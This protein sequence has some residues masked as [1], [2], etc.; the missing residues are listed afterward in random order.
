MLFTLEMETEEQYREFTFPFN[1]VKWNL[2]LLSVSYQCGVVRSQPCFHQLHVLSTTLS[3]SSLA[4]FSL[5]IV[6]FPTVVNS[7][8]MFRI[9]MYDRLKLHTQYAVSCKLLEVTSST[10]FV[11]LTCS[12]DY[13]LTWAKWLVSARREPFNSSCSSSRSFNFSWSDLK[14]IMIKCPE[15]R[16]MKI[17][18]FNNWCRRQIND[19]TQPEK[20]DWRKLHVVNIIH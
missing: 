6:P 20:P 19:N 11:V 7:E 8:I 15:L 18:I 16:K 17:I 12:K 2:T 9:Y 10:S 4:L 1:E 13:F 3:W 14:R 5:W